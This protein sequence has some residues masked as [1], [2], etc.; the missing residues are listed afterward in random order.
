MKTLRFESSSL[1]EGAKSFQLVG[2]LHCLWMCGPLVLAYSLHIKGR[3]AP[4][5][6]SL[7][8]AG[9]LHHAAFHSGRL[10]TYGFL[11]SKGVRAIV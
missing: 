2:S 9:L 5:S 1:K 8:R 10:F 11:I 6:K 3:E 7:F 4:A